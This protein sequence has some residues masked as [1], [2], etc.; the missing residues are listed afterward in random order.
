MKRNYTN[1]EVDARMWNSSGIGRFLR[2][3]VQRAPSDLNIMLRGN[4]DVP[5]VATVDASPIYSL[6]EQFTR[7]GSGSVVWVPHF[8]ISWLDMRER[9]VTIHD[10]APLAL[11][12]VFGRGLRRWYAWSFMWFLGKTSR[13]V[14]FVSKFTLS[15]Y[16]FYLGF[17][18]RSSSVVLNGVDSFWTKGLN[19]E[20]EHFKINQP[21][22]RILVVGNLK[23]HKNILQVCAALREMGDRGQVELRVVGKRDGFITGA[24]RLPECTWIKLLGQISDEELRSEYRCASCFV[25]PSLYEGFGLPILEAMSAGCLVAISDIPVFREICMTDNQVQIAE[26]FDPRSTDDVRKAIT[27]ALSLSPA[28]RICRI[29]ESK[30]HAQY[31]SWESAANKIW[32]VLADVAAHEGEMI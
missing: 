14:F 3:I 7:A 23:E 26:F 31:Y 32:T 27:R 15:E 10:V 17:T 6:R 12:A 2:E 13:H 9:V 28:D 21:A 8:N 1:I 16:R 20:A 18:P 5:N 25:M 22:K 11:P 24:V 19:S 29:E 30:R 4:L